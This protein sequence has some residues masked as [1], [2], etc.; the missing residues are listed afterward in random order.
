MHLSCRTEGPPHLGYHHLDYTDLG[1]G[2]VYPHLVFLGQGLFQLIPFIWVLLWELNNLAPWPPA[3]Q[4][5]RPGLPHLQVNSEARD[6]DS[7]L[8]YIFLAT[9][10]ILGGNGS[11]KCELLAI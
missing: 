1:Y 6:D 7:L 11:T 3:A 5:V 4:S 9:N 10:T 2:L 8:Q